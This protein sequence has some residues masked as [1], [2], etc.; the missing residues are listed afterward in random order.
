MTFFS[1]PY[2]SILFY[3]LNLPI[4]S[5]D[6]SLLED[7]YLFVSV[8]YS[9]TNLLIFLFYLTISEYLINATF[10]KKLMNLKVISIKKRK[11]SFFQ[12]MLR[13]LAKSVFLQLFLFD[14]FPMIFDK[15]KRRV[16]DY[17]VKTVV[18]ENKKTIKKYGDVIN[19]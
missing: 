19:I 1:L 15:Q 10:G 14:C 2:M 6:I 17:I 11:L 13:N 16:S 5:L 4:D 8:I 18:V 3:N 7:K 9:F 12:A